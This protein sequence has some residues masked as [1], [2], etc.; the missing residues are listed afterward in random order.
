MKIGGGGVL[1]ITITA[2]LSSK[3]IKTLRQ[4]S[5]IDSLS[6]TI[7][8]MMLVKILLNINTKIKRI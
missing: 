3:E 8:L 2:F 5:Q 4:I 6:S 1:T 7:N